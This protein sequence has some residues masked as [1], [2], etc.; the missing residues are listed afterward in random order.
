M[1]RVLGVGSVETLAN[2]GMV[3]AP[4]AIFAVVTALLAI[5]FVVTLPSGWSSVG[6]VRWAERVVP[7]WLVS[8][9]PTRP[10]RPAR[11]S[12]GVASQAMPKMA[13]MRFFSRSVRFR[14]RWKSVSSGPMFRGSPG[15]GT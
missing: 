15:S 7:P 12:G 4:S 11:V 2:F 1:V 10:A 9:V 8:N 13:A 14:R 5:L 3:T 6:A